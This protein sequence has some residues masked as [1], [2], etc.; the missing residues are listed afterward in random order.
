[1]I[2]EDS[3]ASRM[4]SGSSG[5]EHLLRV[6][7][8]SDLHLQIHPHDYIADRAAP[9]TGLARIAR[10][11]ERLRQGAD[12]CVLLDNGDFLEGNALGDLIVA[13]GPA[14]VRAHPMIAAMNALGY[15]AATLGNHEFSFGIR[16]LAD[17]LSAA[18]FAVVSA[19][20]ALR[21]AGAP[22]IQPD[23]IL[24]RR[25]SDGSCLRLG[26]TGALPPQ[27][28]VWDR[29]HL[30]GRAEVRP[31]LPAVAEAVQNLRARGAD[32]V[33]VL[34]HSGL[35][36][37]PEQR[38]RRDEAIADAVAALPGV[39]AVVAGHTHGVHPPA[40]SSAPPAPMQRARPG[41]HAPIVMPGSGGTHLGLIDLV[42]GRG[43]EGRW[44]I[45]C[46]EARCLD[47]RDRLEGERT[48]RGI[49]R[50]L[51]D[52]AGP[53]HRATLAAIRAP[54]GETAVHLH[55]H[56]C[57]LAPAPA[58]RLVAAVQA[59]AVERALRDGPFAELP[60]LS[61]A[62]PYR[63]ASGD[64]TGPA[65]DIPPGP[66]RM[67]H[68]HDLCPYPN[69]IAARL[70]DGA[71]LRLWL[72]H[73]SRIFAEPSAADGRASPLLRTDAVL[74][75]FDTIEGLHYE[76]DLGARAEGG[77]RVI[78]DLSHR[79]RRVHDADRFVL[80]ASGYRLS[81][82]GGFP[83][84]PDGAHLFD[85]LGGLREALLAR[86]ATGAPIR[87]A[88]GPVWRLR[89]GA[90]TL[91]TLLAPLAARVCLGDPAL[92]QDIYVERTRAGGPLALTV[93]F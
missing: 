10:I 1:M 85:A 36:Q 7:A 37:D 68:L 80:A 75:T 74:Y 69:T 11:V 32:L 65:T 82:G 12:A 88:P 41:G 8:T 90:G 87:L 48:R 2:A 53:A 60:V 25:L 17:A 59:E 24:E 76:I 39:D 72:E 6:L 18:R 50:R 54:V 3:W 83:P 56:L 46:S 79:G 9:A 45:L 47:A 67:A 92:P 73:A 38:P 33:V 71:G 93:R 61:A 4:R 26:V 89:G 62:A 49:S 23:V 40:D 27:V 15:D 28:M 22:P 81:G 21:V 51:I 19:N 30:A 84:T 13:S 44:Q 31:I 42:L 55:T 57:A 20:L 86:L 43:P 34:C 58:V 70:I 78:R 91:R 77:G 35:P 29:A 14:A 64:G 66:L 63:A 16:V 5:D 52:L